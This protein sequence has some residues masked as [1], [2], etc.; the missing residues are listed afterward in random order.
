MNYLP[1]NTKEGEVI[2]KAEPPLYSTKL[3]EHSISS[4][5]YQSKDTVFSC[6]VLSGTATGLK[7]RVL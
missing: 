6:Q 5:T 7:L 1:L 3:S 4:R 2:L